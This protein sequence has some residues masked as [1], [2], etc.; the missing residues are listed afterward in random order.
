MSEI[1]IH[2]HSLFVPENASVLILGS[3]PGKNNILVEGN[4]EWFYS[5][6]RNQFWHILR[7]VY[8]ELSSEGKDIVDSS[9][10]ELF[11][12]ENYLTKIELNL[13]YIIQI[14]SIRH[15]HPKE[16][17]FVKLFDRETNH[18]LKR[19]IIVAMTNW[20]SHYWLVDI[21]N[22]F[23][24]LSTWER[25]AFIYSSYC[26]GD[27]GKH[28]RGSNKNLFSKEELLIRDWCSERKSTNKPILV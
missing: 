12:T 20:E 10:L 1:E 11:K 6:K 22:Q 7:S 26:L 15:S 21:K 9:L 4:D 28:W 27:E 23:T 25:R 8:D 5:A 2:P 14:L 18:L 24:T 19:Q 3:F 17:L 16:E 13:N